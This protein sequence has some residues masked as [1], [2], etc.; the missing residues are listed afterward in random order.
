MRF[1]FL[2]LGFLG[3]ELLASEVQV[4]SLQSCPEQYFTVESV[5]GEAFQGDLSPELAAVATLSNFPSCSES[6]VSISIAT[7]VCHKF[8]GY[9]DVCAV[10]SDIG[11]FLVVKDSVDGATIHAFQAEGMK[12]LEFEDSDQF[13]VPDFQPCYQE[14]LRLDNETAPG[15]RDHR[16]WWAQTD[17]EFTDPRLAFSLGLREA[18]LDLGLTCKKFTGY[19]DIP[20]DSCVNLGGI[21]TCFID[22]NGGFNIAA[23]ADAMIFALGF[24]RWD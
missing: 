7:V 17:R 4:P 13:I 10:P 9:I 20:K 11:R 22:G 6:K 23:R 2:V 19:K 21:Q 12:S 1:I 14:I 18:H 24:Y 16:A 3:A 8:Q 15:S 5:N